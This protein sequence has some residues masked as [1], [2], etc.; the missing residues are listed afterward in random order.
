MESEVDIFDDIVDDQLTNK[1]NE[2]SLNQIIF[3]LSRRINGPISIM[4]NNTT[5]H[6]KL[7]DKD[8]LNLG[9]EEAVVAFCNEKG[10]DIAEEVSRDMQ[11][12]QTKQNNKFTC[13]PNGWLVV[14]L[15]L[16]EYHIVG[17]ED[18]LASIIDKLWQRCDKE[19]P[20]QFPYNLIAVFELG[21]RLAVSIRPIVSSIEKYDKQK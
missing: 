9:L 21:D 10:I 20:E 4:H 2:T 8:H 11:K 18:S 1:N 15:A 7:Y 3:W 13:P 19:M 17:N 6:L 12:P 16:G 14:C 5:A